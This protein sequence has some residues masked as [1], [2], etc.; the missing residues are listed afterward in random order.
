MPP[1]IESHRRQFTAKKTV[2]SSPPLAKNTN[3]PKRGFKNERNEL[4]Q[5]SHTLSLSL[6]PLEYE[7]LADW[8]GQFPQDPV[9]VDN[10][11]RQ[12]NAGQSYMWHLDSWAGES[13]GAR[14]EGGPACLRR[15][16]SGWGTSKAGLS[17]LSFDC[18]IPKQLRREGR[19]GRRLLPLPQC[20]DHFWPHPMPCHPTPCHAQQHPRHLARRYLHTPMHGR[21]E[22]PA[23]L[24][25]HQSIVMCFHP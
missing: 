19:R 14:V 2:P 6:V 4:T 1:R 12:A 23:G 3:K 18:A 21:P 5:V 15:R 8:W 24:F 17:Y 22:S 20:L 13:D 16:T 25:Y 10:A 7:T 11:G 9:R